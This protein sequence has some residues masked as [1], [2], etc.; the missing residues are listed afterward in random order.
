MNEC[1]I[2]IDLGGTKIKVALVDRSGQIYYNQK[3]PT[4]A[5]LG[6]QSVIQAI[7]QEVAKLQSSKEYQIKALGIGVAGQIEAD[8]GIVKFAPNLKWH[9]VALKSGL[10]HQIHLPVAVVDDVKAAAYGEWKYGAGKGCSDLVCMFIGTGIGGGIIA[11]GK[12][13]GGG[14]NTAGEI[15]HM[16]VEQ[17]GPECTCGN[18]G[19]VE[20]IGGGWAIAK[21]AKEMVKN[22]RQAGQYLLDCCQSIDEITAA[23]VA[24]GAQKGDPLCQKVIGNAVNAIVACS[25]NIVN[26]LNP[27]K[28]IVGG[29][30]VKGI[31]HLLD[32]IRKGIKARALAA[33][34]GNLEVVD[35]ALGD[36]AGVVGAATY[37]L[38]QV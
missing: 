22:D 35:A 25:V 36:N 3:I 34:C 32:E 14:S 13:F 37:A 16:I 2:G 30:V 4:R 17:N 1:A 38:D 26:V 29:G 21:H 15:G 9:N 12:L 5:E 24:L 11:N 18:W 28:L 6:S 27:I 31:P 8:S 7:V 20:A 10:Y 19:C 33:A 23:H